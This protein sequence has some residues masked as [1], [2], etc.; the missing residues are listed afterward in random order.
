[1]RTEVSD[2][3]QCGTPRVNGQVVVPAG[4]QV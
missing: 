1:M 2:V 3:R 4:G